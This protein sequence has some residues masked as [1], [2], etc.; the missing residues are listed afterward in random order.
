MTSRYLNEIFSI[1][2]GS[3]GL[4]RI[5][6]G[7]L[8]LCDLISRIIYGYDLISPDGVFSVRQAFKVLEGK[9]ILSV[10]LI[11]ES[12]WY[13]YFLLV[14]SVVCYVS[15]LVGFKEKIFGVFSL[16]LFYS[17]QNRNPFVLHGGDILLRVFLLLSLFLPIGSY[18]IC[19]KSNNKTEG[20]ASIV[21]A[22]L[23]VQI[24]IMY[25]FS[26]LYKT[27]PEWLSGSALFYALKLDWTSN[28][29]GQSLTA[30]PQILRILTYFILGLEILIL[31]LLFV[32]FKRTIIRGSLFVALFFF[33]ICIF[34]TM[35]I[36]TF[37]F[38][39]LLGVF[40]L[41]P[42]K[43]SRIQSNF[44]LNFKNTSAMLILSLMIFNNVYYYIQSENTGFTKS[45]LV[46]SGLYQKWSMFS[47][48]PA[49]TNVRLVI[50]TELDSID[51]RQA[52]PTH[53]WQKYFM[54]M[55][56][57]KN[58]EL[59]NLF[60]EYLCRKYSANSIRIIVNVRD[61]VTNADLRSQRLDS[62][63]CEAF[64]AI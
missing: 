35:D 1:N 25:F 56:R 46:N 3:L 22:T 28:S 55:V 41:F 18:S 12:L 36:G 42:S 44:D 63:E 19:S 62:T 50:K 5:G 39:C 8:L 10:Y 9:S 29:F 49:K 45:L 24:G 33:H 37:P 27:G 32:K 48:S 30:V 54:Q 51:T 7:V 23:F 2:L 21:T 52:F 40:I 53:H 31:P 11:S 58:S 4:F 17:I 57:P 61:S 13:F 15:Y 43:S 34:M 26:A 60:S 47:P 38:V 16:I 64:R 14:L 6:I 20:Y 59:V